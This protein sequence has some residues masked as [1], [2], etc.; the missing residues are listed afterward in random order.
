MRVLT[1][2]EVAYL[3]KQEKIPENNK[4][5][6]FTLMMEGPVEVLVV[7]KLAAVYDAKILFDGASPF[8]RRRI[9]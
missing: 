1:A 5:L 6:Y 2:G 9:N 8:G 7:S 3:L 4:D